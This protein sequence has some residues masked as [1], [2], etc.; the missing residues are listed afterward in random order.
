[1][2]KFCHCTH[3]VS[4]NEFRCIDGK[5]VDSKLICDGMPP[6]CEDQSDLAYCAQNM[7]ISCIRPKYQECPL[8][9]ECFLPDLK[10]GIIF[11]Y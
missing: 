5:C 2:S 10:R 9:K 11:Q 7:S 4:E 1:M 8:I 3:I 6:Q